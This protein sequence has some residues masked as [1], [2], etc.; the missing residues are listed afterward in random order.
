M[1]KNADFLTRQFPAD[2]V[3]RCL[4]ASCND[5]IAAFGSESAGDGESD[6]TSGAGNQ[7][8]LTSQAASSYVS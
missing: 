4:V 5:Q 1:G 2:A 8:N 7:S 3:E 6:A